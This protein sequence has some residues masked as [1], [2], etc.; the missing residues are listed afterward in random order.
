MK[1]V[2]LAAIEQFRKRRNISQAEVARRL[3]YKD[4]SSYTKIKKGEQ[5]ISIN[6]LIRV[7]EVLNIP[8]RELIEAVFFGNDV[9]FESSA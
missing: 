3:G 9:D 7:A 6:Q 5:D 1:K 2:N 8:L 4:R